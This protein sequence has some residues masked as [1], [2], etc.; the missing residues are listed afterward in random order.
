MFI[1]KKSLWNYWV[2]FINTPLESVTICVRAVCC[3][4]KKQNIHHFSTYD[5][6]S[7]FPYSR[8]FTSKLD[9]EIKRE[10]SRQSKYKL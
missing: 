9:I 2:S 7:R 1:K 10:V 5:G 6:Q 8:G 3:Q 4:N